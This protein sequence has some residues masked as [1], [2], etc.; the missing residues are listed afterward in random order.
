MVLSL[1]L[2]HLSAFAG[3]SLEN[4]ARSEEWHRL[5]YYRNHWGFGVRSA[6]DGK[7]FFL[8]P[9]GH[10][11]PLAEL[12]ATIDAL[13]HSERTYGPRKQLAYCA[14]PARRIFLERRLGKEFPAKPCADYQ[15]YLTKLAARSIS[16]VY[17]TSYPNN[18]ASMFGHTFFRV[19]SRN[20]ASSKDLSLLDTSVNYAAQVPPDENPFAFAWFGLTGGY[21]G[22][23]SLVP[24]FAKV[25]EYGFFEGRDLWEYEL[26]LS[27]AELEMAL[28]ALWE[29][30]TNS[31]FDYYFFDENCSLQLLLILEIARPDWR[32]SSHFIHMIPGESIRRVAEVPNAVRSVRFRPSLQRR[33]GA[34]VEAL[35]PEERKQWRQLRAGGAVD[36]A[37]RAP[38]VAYSLYLQT[39][40]QANKDRWP[41]EQKKR[42]REVLLAIAAS[43]TEVKEAEVPPNGRGPEAGHGAY[44]IGLGGRFHRHGSAGGVLSLR[45]AYHDLL[46]FDEGYRPNNEFRFPNLSLLWREG[47]LRLD[48]GEVFSIVSLTPWNLVSRPFSWRGRVFWGDDFFSGRTWR[49]E[50][51]LGSAWSL[52]GERATFWAMALGSVEI[53]SG[54]S[55]PWIQP[56]LGVESGLLFQWHAVKFLG[57]VRAERAF[58]KRAWRIPLRTGASL[59]LGQDWS[60]RGELLWKK[61]KNRTPSQPFEASLQVIRYF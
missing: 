30:E 51:G 5:L 23:F 26:N 42:E 19:A 16:L 54:L 44:G 36:G 28:A 41:D 32:I 61:S 6:V 33:L 48:Q 34:Q 15:E 17:A 14:F 11:D 49:G 43:K 45:P 27:P 2:L 21:Q 29:I 25:E 39:E 13:S 37:Q 53:P 59:S 3:D 35:S 56:S 7:E 58:W 10:K 60:L 40:K 8:A 12:Q 57:S 24:F 50:A 52:A 38:L 20:N 22:R 55:G 47:R 4:I 9:S 1:L 31:F 46:D 18:P